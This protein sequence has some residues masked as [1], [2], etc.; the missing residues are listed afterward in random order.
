MDTSLVNH[1][2]N[3]A[4]QLNQVRQADAV[5]TAVLRRTLD[6][7]EASASVMLDALAAATPV[8]S[9]TPAASGPLGT[10]VDTWA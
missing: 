4:V 8:P 2:L 1:I 7:Q 9:T 10:Q 6:M 3:T 5:Q